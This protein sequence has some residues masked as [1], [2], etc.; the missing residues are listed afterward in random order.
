ML[1]LKRPRSPISRTILGL[2]YEDLVVVREVHLLSGDEVTYPK[3]YWVNFA[4][5]ADGKGGH[6]RSQLG[7]IRK[8]V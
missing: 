3:S 7:H 4:D 8:W 5:D 1:S 6:A 2:K